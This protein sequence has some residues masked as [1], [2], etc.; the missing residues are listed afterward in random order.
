MTSTSTSSRSRPT[1]HRP[2]KHPTM[3]DTFDPYRKW[4]GIPPEEQPPHYYRLLAIS[5]FESDPDVI[6]NAAD[7]RMSQVK[8]YQAGPHA[9]VSQQILNQIAAA[10]VCLLDPQKKAAYDRRLR[11]K[12]QAAEFDLSSLATGSL[13]SADHRYM[14]PVTPKKKKPISWLAPAIAAGALVLAGSAAA[15]VFMLP[16]GGQV[17]SEG[18]KTPS[19]AA[20]PPER[21]S[22]LPKSA[23]NPAAQ[24]RVAAEAGLTAGPTAC[25]TGC[26]SGCR[27]P[28]RHRRRRAGPSRVAEIEPSPVP[29]PSPLPGGIKTGAQG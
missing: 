20:P 13:S 7:G 14:V 11:E 17:A 26:A 2:S 29:T 19:S 27:R 4:L 22:N 23:F 25:S 18:K 9:K 12:L 10:K 3:P 5:P 8:S 6:S 16:Q 15:V 21:G 24:R 28:S 1:A